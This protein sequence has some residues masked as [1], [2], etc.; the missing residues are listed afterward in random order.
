MG[1]LAHELFVNSPLVVFPMFALGLFMIV[2]VVVVVR[3]FS[4]PMSEHNRHAA[5]PLHDDG[6]VLSKPEAAQKVV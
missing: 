3:A 6:E 4:Q 5:L 1:R 2:F